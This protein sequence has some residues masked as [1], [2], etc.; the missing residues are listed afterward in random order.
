ML[1]FPLNGKPSLKKCLVFPSSQ[2]MKCHLLFQN[3]GAS[4]LLVKFL[5]FEN[6]Y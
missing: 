4:E 6:K 1:E 3:S 5:G 2:N